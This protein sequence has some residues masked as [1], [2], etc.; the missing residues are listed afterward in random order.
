M[1]SRG[2]KVCDDMRWPIWYG[3][4]LIPRIA[5]LRAVA[6][7]GTASVVCHIAT[8]PGGSSSI[9]E[10]SYQSLSDGVKAFYNS[11]HHEIYVGVE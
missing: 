3:V 8:M 6:C 7:V 10:G 11:S 4:G 5:R 1:F 2:S 9:V